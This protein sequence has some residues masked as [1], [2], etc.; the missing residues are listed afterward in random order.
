MIPTGNRFLGN[1]LHN[2]LLSLTIGLL[3]SL[4][5]CGMSWAQTTYYSSNSS[6]SAPDSA[7]T[8][9]NSAA[10]AQRSSSDS[11]FPNVIVILT[12]DQGWGDLSCHGN[13]NLATP[14]IDR[15]S[16]LGARFDRFY[17]CPVCS[18]T[19]AEFLTGRYHP[20]CGVT[21][22][23]E[24]HE[25]LDL[26]ERTI[27]QHFRGAGYAT[28]CF[29]K[30]HN[31]T[32]Y[33]YHPLGRGFDE[34]YGFTSGHWGDYFSPELDHNGR[35]VQ[36]EGFL[37]DDLTDRALKF[38]EAHTQ[39][40]FFLYLSIPTP[41]SPMQAPL[42][43]WQRHRERDYT[44]KARPEDSEDLNFTRAA[45]SMV[46]NI[47]DNVGRLLN[48][49]DQLGLARNTIVTY[50]CDNGPNSARWNDDMKGRKGSVDEGGVRSPL[51]ISWPA[52]I[53]PGRLLTQISSV[54]DLL[55]TL[56]ELAGVPLVTLKPLDGVSLKPLLAGEQVSIPNRLI[57]SHWNR[58]ISVRSQQH[59]LDA[60]GQLFDMLAD[61][62]Q[63]RDIAAQQPEIVQR[64]HAAANGYKN[65][66]LTELDATPRPFMVGHP[67]FHSTMLPARD[68]IPHGNVRRSAK[69]PNCSY[70]T[71]LISPEDSISWFIETPIA[72]RFAVELHYACPQSAVGTEVQLSLGGQTSRAIVELANDA[73]A[74]GAE[75]DLFPRQ[76]ESYVKDFKPMQ[77][78]VMELGPGVGQLKLQS[79]QV[80]GDHGVEVQMLVLRR[81][82]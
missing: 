44:M 17:V 2:M 11:Q 43:Y 49:L 40:K 45:M 77:L 58:Q 32:Q 54:T 10:V 24:G 56:A 70:F 19:R 37:V 41:H 73:P 1:S 3:F 79:P 31:G 29:G 72:G 35:Q 38:V 12:D 8:E 39:E 68:G 55:P 13:T 14:N 82:P 28:A 65:R 34:F 23:S 81:V 78:G 62:G 61:P 48:R 51:F 46:E 47:D 59:R 5:F 4:N 57:C 67:D 63:R 80:V 25:R 9:Q 71:N 26:D 60:R 50:F 74:R 64:L 33:P 69:A 53:E 27:A 42:S 22:V 52:R 75:Q 6:Q 36:G 18:T 66:V 7:A 15:L 16:K 20:R 21:G 76:S 30:W